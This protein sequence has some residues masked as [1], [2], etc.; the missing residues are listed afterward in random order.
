M[1]IGEGLFSAIPNMAFVVIH[2]VAALVA[3]YYLF[4]SSG[5]DKMLTWAFVL[6]AVSAALYALVH[7]A[8]VDQYTTH[9]L[10]SVFML[11]ATILVGVHAV[12]CK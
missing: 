3:L 6:L 2:A 12:K 11:I 5:G 8:V 7:L 4:K 9:V 10:E 1:A